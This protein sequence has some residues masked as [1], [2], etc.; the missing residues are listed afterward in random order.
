MKAKQI[1]LSKLKRGICPSCGA[2]EKTIQTSEQLIR[3]PVINTKILKSHGCSGVIDV[4][5]YCKECETRE[6]YAMPN[7]SNCDL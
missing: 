5:Y 3:I 2:E 4:E 7:N 6:V 1:K